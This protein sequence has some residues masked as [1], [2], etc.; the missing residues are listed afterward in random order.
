MADWPSAPLS[1]Q[2]LFRRDRTTPHMACEAAPVSL[3]FPLAERTM[4][5]LTKSEERMNRQH[6]KSNVFNLL[7]VLPSG[8]Q[9]NRSKK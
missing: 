2:S 4:P 3:F 1:E 9:E 7:T 5:G 8:S 6:K